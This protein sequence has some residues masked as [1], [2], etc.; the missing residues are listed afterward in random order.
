M[1]V[2]DNQCIEVFASK[3]RNNDIIGIDKTESENELELGSPEGCSRLK[4]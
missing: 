1:S 4:N 3:K 2:T